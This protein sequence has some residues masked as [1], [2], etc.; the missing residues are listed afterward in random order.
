VTL[1]NPHEA[2]LLRTAEVLQLLRFKK[3]KLHALQDPKSAYHDPTFPKA[4]YLGRSRTPL[5]LS[6]ELHEWI[7]VS[8]RGKALVPS[9]T[10]AAWP[11]GRIEPQGRVNEPSPAGAAGDGCDVER[12]VGETDNRPSQMS[13]YLAGRNAADALSWMPASQGARRSR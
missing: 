2:V 12:D 13:R 9:S 3:T 7:A 6:T 1:S 11:S 10:L 5:W 8:L 4:R